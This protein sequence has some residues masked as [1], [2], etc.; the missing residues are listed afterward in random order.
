M[1]QV[2][3][4]SDPV[5]LRVSLSISLI[6]S[7]TGQELGFSEPQFVYLESGGA[8]YTALT[9]VLAGFTIPFQIPFHSVICKQRGTIKR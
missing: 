4:L 1:G 9:V 6:S 3:S 5:P 2:D 8:P 7:L